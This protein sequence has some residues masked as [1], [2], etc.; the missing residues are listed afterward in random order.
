[1]CI[2]DRCCDIVCAGGERQVGDID[3]FETHPVE[4]VAK[5]AKGNA[6]VRQQ[7]REA[8]DLGFGQPRGSLVEHDH[9][10]GFVTGPED[11]VDQALR[12]GDAAAAWAAV[13]IDER[14]GVGARVASP[15]A[16]NR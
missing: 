13:E 15:K 7:H 1:M 4:A 5:R 14:L 12:R 11:C 8:D 10:T 9:V 3:P 16:H 6:L 2:R